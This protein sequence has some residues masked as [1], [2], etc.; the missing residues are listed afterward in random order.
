MCVFLADYIVIRVYSIAADTGRVDR[1]LFD[2]DM[3]LNSLAMK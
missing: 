3:F 1:L 2:E